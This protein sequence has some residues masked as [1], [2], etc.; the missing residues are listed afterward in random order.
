MRDHLFGRALRHNHTIRQNVAAVGNTQRRAHIMIRDQYADTALSQR[1]HNLLQLLDGLWVDTS[2]GFVEQQEGRLKR[3][4]TGN[5]DA[6]PLT[7]RQLISALMAQ[8]Q[9]VKLLHQAFSTGAPFRPK[10]PVHFQHQMEILLHGQRAEYGRLLREVADAQSGA[11]IHRQAR[12]FALAQKHAPT[13]RTHQPNH[14]IESGCLTRTVGPQQPDNLA[15]CHLQRD[16][17]YY[18]LLA[19]RFFEPLRPQSHLGGGLYL[20]ARYNHA[21]HAMSRPKGYWALVLHSHIP[22]VLT[23]GR[24]PHGTDWLVEAVAECY[25]PLWELSQR[26]LQQ[27]IPA[28]YTISFTPILQEQL[29]SDAFRAEMHGYL[30][31]KQ[32]TACTDMHEF[33]QHGIRWQAGLAYFWQRFYER[34]QALLNELNGDLLGGFR[35]LQDSGAIEIITSAATHGYLPLIGHDECVR[36]QVLLGT[37]AYKCHFGREP[38]GFWLPECAYRPG[39]RWTPPVAREVI[40]PYERWGIEQ[41]LSEAGVRYFFVDTHMLRGG[42]P[43]GTYLTRFPALA[44]LFKQ[45]QRAYQGERSERSHYRAY[46]LPA[47]TPLA[48]FARDPATTLQVWSG[49]HGYPGDARYL[50]FHKQHYP[51]RLRYWRVSENKADLAAKQPYEPYAAFEAA[52]AHA[53]H[54]VGLLKQVLGDHYARTGEPGV[55]VSMYDTELFGHWWFEGPEWLFAVI[56]RI[57]VDPELEMVTCSD[58]YERFPPEEL[59]A[60]PEGSWGEGGFHYIWLNEQTAR[61]WEQLYRAEAHFLRLLRR[62]RGDATFQPYLQQL[63]REL[64]LLQSSDWAFLI[65]TGAARDYAELRFQ[66]HLRRFESIAILIEQQASRKE[67]DASLLALYQDSLQREPIFDDLPL[68]LW[69]IP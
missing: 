4:G 44:Q 13:V 46:W 56:Q 2:E 54:F 45:F 19:V 37:L 39:Y 55:L 62:Y 22:Y 59:I 43:L 49:E 60:L 35:Q 6:A 63:A 14:H 27:G 36:A 8:V 17:P 34:Q 7:S 11:P 57:A 23:H 20:I 50:E 25:L 30:Q 12:D 15:T 31:F 52:Q 61:V 9:N 58:Y 33:R 68:D 18:G 5:L 65:T 53:D 28:R 42:E 41:F 51:G 64:L 1:E 69:Q 66:D 40:P 26:L 48:V 16:I 29:A 10:Y 24:T 47:P 38:N 3:E 32:E 67:P 21:E